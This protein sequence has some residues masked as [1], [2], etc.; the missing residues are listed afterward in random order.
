[1]RNRKPGPL[2]RG[3]PQRH[4]A[5]NLSRRSQGGPSANGFHSHIRADQL[6]PRSSSSDDSSDSESGSSD[7]DAPP[8]SLS[9]DDEDTSRL[10]PPRVATRRI[11]ATASITIE[12]ISDFDSEDGRRPVLRPCAIEEFDS[13]RS[14]SRS[15]NPE[16]LPGSML[17]G[18]RDL[19]CGSDSEEFD[20]EQ[21]EMEVFR[22]KHR[23][24]K[25][26]KRLNSG[27]IGKRTITESIGSDSDRADIRPVFFLDA[28]ELGSSARRLRRRL[29]NR[30]SLQFQDPPPRLDELDEPNT[31]DDDM[32]EVGEA[33]AKE[34]P[35]YD[36]ISME[37]DSS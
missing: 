36:Y 34:L 30:Q 18:M 14:R 15:R 37:I 22:Q 27:S 10:R 29:G 20:L 2:G 7:S 1:V 9:S 35:Y 6:S 3:Q 12:E 4:S 16:D 24:E 5:R 28:S 32:V 23:E 19:S 8:R 21:A 31:S 33:L 13:E 25:R 17:S 11:I 26:R